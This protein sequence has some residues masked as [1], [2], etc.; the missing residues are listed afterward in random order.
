MS[1]GRMPLELQEID[2]VDVAREAAGRF[3]ADGES[4]STITVNADGPVVGYWDRLRIEQIVTNLL[5]N[6]MKYGEGRPVQ[7]TLAAEDGACRIRVRDHG[8]GIPDDAQ[9]RIFDRFERVAP[10][11]NYGGFGLGLWIVRQIVEAHGGRIAVSSRPGEGSEF[12]V[13]LP[14]SLPAGGAPRAETRAPEEE[15]VAP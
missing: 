11:Q 2:L 3:A 10:L 4:R 1:V 7:V 9:H 14:R 13:E 8:I 12:T 15:A 6:A 5:S